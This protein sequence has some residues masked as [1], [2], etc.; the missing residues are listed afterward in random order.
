[1]LACLHPNSH[2]FAVLLSAMAVWLFQACLFLEEH[3]VGSLFWA[4]FSLVIR[5][6]ASSVVHHLLEDLSISLALKV[7]ILQGIWQNP[8]EQKIGFSKSQPTS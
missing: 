8:R 7:D 2:I 5:L 4:V 1:M 6:G 3:K